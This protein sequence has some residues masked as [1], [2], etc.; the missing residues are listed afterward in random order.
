MPGLLAVSILGRKKSA[1]LPV[2]F[3]SVVSETPFL[4]IFVRAHF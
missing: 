4:P 1:V 3:D 2:L